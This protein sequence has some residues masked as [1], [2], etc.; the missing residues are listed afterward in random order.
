MSI[1][2]NARQAGLLSVSRTVG[3]GAVRPWLPAGETLSARLFRRGL[4]PGTGVPWIDE[5]GTVDAQVR[6]LY[7]VSL[8][9]HASSVAL[10][11]L[12]L[13]SADGSV[14]DL[15][16]RAPSRD[17]RTPAAARRALGRAGGRAGG[18]EGMLTTP[19]PYVVAGVAGGMLSLGA[20]QCG[21]ETFELSCIA[22]DGEWRDF[23]D[24]RISPRPRGGLPLRVDPV[25]HALPGLEI[26][27]PAPR[28]G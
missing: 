5:S 20:R 6:L 7:G 21:T 14:G 12:R 11:A 15:L 22:G 23:A 27:I 8:T 19:T 1:L 13:E 17:R 25:A 3:L 26:S 10:L 18:R 9:G 2:A 28:N 4:E 16:L 24:L